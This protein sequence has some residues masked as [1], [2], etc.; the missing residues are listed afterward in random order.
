ME[1]SSNTI[2]LDNHRAIC[3][4]TYFCDKLE[5]TVRFKRGDLINY[6]LFENFIIILGDG[7]SVSKKE[8]Y[9]HFTDISDWRECRINEILE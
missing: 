9:K 3:V 8:F 1:D 2:S 5:G 7:L 6:L 4:R